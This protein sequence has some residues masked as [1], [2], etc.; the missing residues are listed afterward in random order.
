MT[1]MSEFPADIIETAKQA[2]RVLMR[3]PFPDGGWQA[4]A[5]ALFAERERHD[6]EPISQVNPVDG[7]I[8]IGYGE[9][10]ERDGFSPAFMR[11]YDSVAGWSVNG[12]PFYPTH[13]KPLPSPPKP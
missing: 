13:F 2:E 7:L 4:I 5:K 6:W 12:M 8:V 1:V 3:A 10:R 11:W 9:Y